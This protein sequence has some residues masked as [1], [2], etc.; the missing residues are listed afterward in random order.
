ME[1]DDLLL[2]YGKEVAIKELD[3][4]KQEDSI[5]SEN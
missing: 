1:V 4:R 2:V 3:D 5:T